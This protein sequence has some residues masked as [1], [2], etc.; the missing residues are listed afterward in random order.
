VAAVS[1]PTSSDVGVRAWPKAAGISAMSAQPAQNTPS[2]IR[3]KHLT[4]AI[5]YLAKSGMG[6]VSAGA[7]RPSLADL[8]GGASGQ[9]DSQLSHRLPREA[10]LLDETAIPAPFTRKNPS[11]E[12]KFSQTVYIRT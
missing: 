3:R 10:T 11:P 4:A 2:M 7:V 5:A 6:G 8:I 9:G 1:A 12:E